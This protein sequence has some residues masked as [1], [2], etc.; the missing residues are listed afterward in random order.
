[1]ASRTLRA[2]DR[3]ADRDLP[4]P[5]KPIAD[6]LHTRAQHSAAFYIDAVRARLYRDFFGP[7]APGPGGLLEPSL[8]HWLPVTVY[9]TVGLAVCLLYNVNFVYI[10]LTTTNV[11]LVA[12]QVVAYWQLPRSP[13]LIWFIATNMG[14]ALGFFLAGMLVLNP[15]SA[16]VWRLPLR[17]TWL[18]VFVLITIGTNDRV[19]QLARSLR[20]KRD[21]FDC[22]EGDLNE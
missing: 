12:A 4:E 3:H 20:I 7:G 8:V 14:K 11:I 9:V 21:L 2:E 13:W 18:V 10:F 15:E 22:R 6:D 16:A 19:Y 1:M 17:I 5:P